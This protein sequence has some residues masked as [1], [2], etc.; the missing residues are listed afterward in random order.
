MYSV[1][2]SYPNYSVSECFLKDGDV[3]RLRFTLAYGKDIGAGSSGYG[4]LESYGKE[5]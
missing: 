5:W 3:V 4:A 1:N 2:G